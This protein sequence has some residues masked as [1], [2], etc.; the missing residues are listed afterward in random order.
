MR[1]VNE[2]GRVGMENEG[3]G[4]E[5]L[6]WRAEARDGSVEMDGLGMKQWGWRDGD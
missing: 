6:S 1:S 2:N 4:I 5:G 3:M